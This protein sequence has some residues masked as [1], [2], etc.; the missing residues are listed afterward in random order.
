MKKI[1]ISDDIYAELKREKG[2]LSFSEY[3]NN[4]LDDFESLND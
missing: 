3:L 1:R 2:K 4:L